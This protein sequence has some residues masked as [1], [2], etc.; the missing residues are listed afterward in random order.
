[1]VRQESLRILITLSVQSGLKLHQ[2]DVTT[3][4]LN[5]M[6]EEEVLM[7]QPEGF[8]VEGKEHLICKLKKSIY[9]LKQFPQCWN[10]ALDTQLK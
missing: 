10:V 1:M 7:K 3:A 9:E 4:F 6:L 8:E 5:G 2:V